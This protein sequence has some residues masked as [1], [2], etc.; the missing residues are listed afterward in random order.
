M[1]ADPW[2]SGDSL[3]EIPDEFVDQIWSS[4]ISKAAGRNLADVDAKRLELESQDKHEAEFVFYIMS[5]S[6]L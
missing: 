2:P 4:L 3:P 1:T 6:G 5:C